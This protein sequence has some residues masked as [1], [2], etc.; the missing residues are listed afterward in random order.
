MNIFPIPSDTSHNLINEKMDTMKYISRYTCRQKK[1]KLFVKISTIFLILLVFYQSIHLITITA[2]LD[3][4]GSSNEIL[5]SGV[6]ITNVDVP[7]IIQRCFS[8]TNVSINVKN[9][10]AIPRCITINVFLTYKNQFGIDRLFKIGSKRAVIEPFSE[11]NISIYSFF[12]GKNLSNWWNIISRTQIGK[13]FDKGS[14]GIQILSGFQLIPPTSHMIRAKTVNMFFNTLCCTIWKPVLLVPPFLSD[15][16]IMKGLIVPKE[17]YGDGNFTTNVSLQNKF[18]I[19][20]PVYIS[21]FVLSSAESFVGNMNPLWMVDFGYVCG[22]FNGNIPKNSIK[23]ITILC[24][25]PKENFQPG[26]FDVR[27]ISLSYIPIEGKNIY[28]E[29]ILWQQIRRLNEYQR[30]TLSEEFWDSFYKYWLNVPI[31]RYG[32]GTWSR[33]VYPLL[34]GKIYLNIKPPI[35]NN[36]ED[37]IDETIQNIKNLTPYFLLLAFSIVCFAALLY[38]IIKIYVH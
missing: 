10:R 9:N 7:D 2:A 23:N 24:Q 34:L 3:A 15:I 38:A 36:I 19:D 25:F 14:I 11:K 13:D 35:Q 30:Q 37:A 4:E 26:Y 17:T 22:S 20:L 31:Y 33:T 27:V 8:R 21:V 18:S 32:V 28:G 6:E 5:V 16:N 29:K 1:T 12:W